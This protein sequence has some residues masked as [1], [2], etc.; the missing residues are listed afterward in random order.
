[1]LVIRNSLEELSLEL[2]DCI[3]AELELVKLGFFFVGKEVDVLEDLSEETMELEK[4]GGS[5]RFDIWD[6]HSV[7]LL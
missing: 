3:N 5:S 6:C 7:P 2:I 1:M 4:W